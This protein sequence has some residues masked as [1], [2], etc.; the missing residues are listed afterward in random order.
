[1]V[2]TVVSSAAKPKVNLRLVEN[3]RH[4]RVRRRPECQSTNRDLYQSTTWLKNKKLTS[5]EKERRPGI[6]F[7]SQKCQESYLFIEGVFFK[8]KGHLQTA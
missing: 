1:M 5:T 3:D 7:A 2:L 6:V 4:R 8:A